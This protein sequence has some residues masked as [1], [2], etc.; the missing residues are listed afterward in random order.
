MWH[1]STDHVTTKTA[2]CSHVTYGVLI[3]WF[4]G[5][6]SCHYSI[7]SLKCVNKMIVKK[8]FYVFTASNSSVCVRVN[9]CSC[10][11]CLTSVKC[12]TVNSP[13]HSVSH[14]DLAVNAI[15]IMCIRENYFFALKVIF[16]YYLRSFPN[17]CHSNECK[18]Y[19]SSF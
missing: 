11:T 15:C 5:Q 6:L 7:F 9:H 19:F 2:D 13:C 12:W 1:C 10:T 16:F 14:W 3:T 4:Y 8:L 17:Y 18:R